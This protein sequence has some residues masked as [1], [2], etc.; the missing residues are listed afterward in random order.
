MISRPEIWEE[1]GY[2]HKNDL[3]ALGVMFYEML[4]FKLP[5]PSDNLY[6]LVFQ[7]RERDYGAIHKMYSSET[8]AIIDEL[9]SYLPK[10]RPECGKK[11]PLFLR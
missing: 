4:T 8:Q 6:E 10:D 3:W 11:L 9:L 1:R 7:I 2:T 5:F